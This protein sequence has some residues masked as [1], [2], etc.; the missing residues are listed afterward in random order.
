VSRALAELVPSSVLY[1]PGVGEVTLGELLAARVPEQ[2][3]DLADPLEPTLAM[4]EH[5]VMNP[6][7]TPEEWRKNHGSGRTRPENEARPE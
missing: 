4:W 7:C 3:P 6:R 5:I 2:V 1:V